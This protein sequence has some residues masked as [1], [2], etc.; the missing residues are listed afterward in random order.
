MV[1]HESRTGEEPASSAGTFVSAIEEDARG[2][3]DKSRGRHEHQGNNVTW[4]DGAGTSK[5]EDAVFCAARA[6]RLWK[7]CVG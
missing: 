1:F 3:E 2:F 4:R 7:C 5:R 6:Y